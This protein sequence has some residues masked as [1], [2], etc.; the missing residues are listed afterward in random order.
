MVNIQS[1]GFKQ[2]RRV[3]LQKESSERG[4]GAGSLLVSLLF[5]VPFCPLVGLCMGL[6]ARRANAAAVIKKGSV[7][8]TCAVTLGFLFTMAQ[9]FVAYRGGEH[10][11]ELTSGP[12]NALKAGLTGD[13]TTFAGAFS[14]SSTS[15]ASAKA[16]LEELEARY[17]EFWGARLSGPIAGDP[18]GGPRM[19]ELVFENGSVAAE[20]AIGFDVALGPS[21]L[22]SR[23]E[24]IFVQDPQRG[25]LGFPMTDPIAIAEQTD[26]TNDH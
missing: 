14:A 25:D 7:L 10:Y 3:V 21:F 6:A 2:E 8:A 23:L 17:G 4:H 22:G 5:F 15:G 11:L 20:A 18:V 1:D 24:Y 16:F 13:A 26:P 19:Y 9:L 12:G